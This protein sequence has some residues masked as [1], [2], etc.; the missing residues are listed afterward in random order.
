[1]ERLN[2]TGVY[3]MNHLL[4]RSKVTLRRMRWMGLLMLL[5]IYD[6]LLTIIPLGVYI[7][8]YIRLCSVHKKIGL[9]KII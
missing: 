2:L 1:M 4:N 3:N 8:M 5:N 9:W 6:I 7:W